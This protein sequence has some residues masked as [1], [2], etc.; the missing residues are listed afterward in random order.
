MLVGVADAEL[1]GFRTAKAG[2]SS[3]FKM[4][5]ML[6]GLLILGRLDAVR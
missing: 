5:S 1:Y 4:D 3:L 6:V 2:L